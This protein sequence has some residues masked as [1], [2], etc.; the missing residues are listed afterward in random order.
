MAVYWVGVANPSELNSSPRTQ[1]SGFAGEG[2]KN[3]EGE[4]ENNI[5]ETVHVVCMISDV[6][7]A[8]VYT[9][10]SQKSHRDRSKQLTS[11]YHSYLF[12]LL[13]GPDEA[14]LAE[15]VPGLEKKA[16]TSKFHWQPCLSLYKIAMLY[17]YSKTA[18]SGPAQ[19]IFEWRSAILGS[20]KYIEMRI[21]G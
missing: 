17:P 13:L 20:N 9:H 1:T 19:F 11:G 2:W 7:V 14:I 3:T 21:F 18:S 10:S 15:N 8:K 12:Q 6:R 5:P 4:L 16:I